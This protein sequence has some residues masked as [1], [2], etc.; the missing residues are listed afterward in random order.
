MNDAEINNVIGECLQGN[1]EPYT[2]IIQQFQAQ[3]Y[4]ICY[5]F[6]GTS[7]DAEDAA[8]E[9]FIKAFHSLR[10]FDSQYKFSTWIFKITVNHCIGITRKK[11]H[12]RNYLLTQFPE[13]KTERA[14]EDTPASLFFK[15]VEQEELREVLRT[16]PAKYRAALILKY[17]RD[18]SYQQISEILDVPKNTAASLILRGKKELRKRLKERAAPAADDVTKQSPSQ[19]KLCTAAKFPTNSS[20]EGA[21]PAAHEGTGNSVPDKKEV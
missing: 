8:A 19:K 9:V 16:I 14:D 10:S 4:R 2:K 21:A 12:E 7:Q 5:H 15:E 11:K 3:V 13:Q 17:Y 20:L 1:N 6:T 18:L